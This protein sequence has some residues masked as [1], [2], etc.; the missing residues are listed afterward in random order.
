MAG[1]VPSKLLPNILSV[2]MVVVV[3]VVCH[4]DVCVLVLEYCY[5]SVI[6]SIKSV[7]LLHVTE[8]QFTDILPGHCVP[9]GSNLG[10]FLCCTSAF[11]LLYFIYRRYC[12]H[13]SSVWFAVT[14]FS[15]R[16][17]VVIVKVCRV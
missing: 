7:L 17:T 15:C 4:S 10:N 5:V 12:W 11:L 8:T 6:A 9:T 1:R 3:V 14:W 13:C 2:V 16:T